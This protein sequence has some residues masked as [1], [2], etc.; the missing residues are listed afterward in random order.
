MHVYDAADCA[1]S[2]EK[3]TRAFQHFD[4]LCSKRLDHCHVIR[5]GNGHIQAI[6]SILHDLNPRAPKTTNH[7]PANSLT[8]VGRMNPGYV[9]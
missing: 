9:S 7:G 4:T 8:K 5:A 3:R 6:N 2:I 1:T